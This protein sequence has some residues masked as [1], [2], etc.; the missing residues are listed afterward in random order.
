M[1]A[2]SV[3]GPGEVGPHGDAERATRRDDAEEDARAMRALGAAGE[4]HVEPELREGL[5][6]ALRGRV[7]DRDRGVVDESCQAAQWSR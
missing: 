7:V 6:L 1:R 5:E 2:E 4:E 3:E